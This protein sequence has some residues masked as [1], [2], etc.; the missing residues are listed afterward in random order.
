MFS[1]KSFFPVWWL[2]LTGGHTFC[3]PK[4]DYMADMLIFPT[5]TYQIIEKMKKL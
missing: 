5:T 4:G 1:M 3:Q 2:L